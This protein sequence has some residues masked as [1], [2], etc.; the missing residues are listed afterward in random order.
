[1]KHNWT[2]KYEL[3][4]KQNDF[5]ARLI[6]DLVYEYGDLEIGDIGHT[7]EPGVVMGH[8]YGS[9][10]HE[11]FSEQRQ[12]GN[13]YKEC[14]KHL[15]IAQGYSNDDYKVLRS[16]KVKNGPIRDIFDDDLC[17]HLNIDFSVWKDVDFS[18][19]SDRDISNSEV[20][21]MLTLPVKVREQDE[22]KAI[23]KIVHKKDD[24]FGEWFECGGKYS[25]HKTRDF[26]SM[27][28]HVVSKLDRFDYNQQCMK[29]DESV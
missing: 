2:T 15:F 20:S 14:P 12:Y 22:Q 6:L 10:H 26:D 3:N 29:K 23:D 9:V 13:Y 7:D 16:L 25:G 11:W 18:G 21:K 5:L 28:Q 8:V 19:E 1:M 24:F 17:L 27:V 4:E